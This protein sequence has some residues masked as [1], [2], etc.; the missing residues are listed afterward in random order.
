MAPIQ[1]NCSQVFS[2]LE[3]STLAKREKNARNC[4]ISHTDSKISSL[5]IFT[6]LMPFSQKVKHLCACSQRLT[7]LW[8]SFLFLPSVRLPFPSSYVLPQWELNSQL[9]CLV[10]SA[11]GGTAKEWGWCCSVISTAL[12]PS[13]VVPLLVPSSSPQRWIPALSLPLAPTYIS[14]VFLLLISGL[15]HLSTCLC[16]LSPPSM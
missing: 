9:S 11:G 5:F 4:T 2:V 10:D 1:K 7:W 12:H 14:N 8:W 3:P 16:L 15:P 13:S 6:T